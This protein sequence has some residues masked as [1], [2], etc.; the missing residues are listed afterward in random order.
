M[1]LILVKPQAM[2]YMMRRGGGSNFSLLRPAP[3]LSFL[4]MTTGHDVDLHKCN[5]QIKFNSKLAG[6]TVI[7]AFLQVNLV[8]C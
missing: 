6:P 4:E 1:Y 7:I 2:I 3:F 5:F 8:H